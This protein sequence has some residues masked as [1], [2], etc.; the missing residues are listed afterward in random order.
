MGKEKKEPIAK[1]QGEKGSNAKAQEGKGRELVKAK[2]E[3]SPKFAT[4][5]P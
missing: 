4:N 2:L 3:N 1:G 5:L